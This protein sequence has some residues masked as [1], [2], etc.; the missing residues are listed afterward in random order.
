MNLKKTKCYYS[1]LMEKNKLFGQ[2]HRSQLCQ[3]TA[4]VSQ[5]PIFPGEVLKCKWMHLYLLEGECPQD[6][7]IYILGNE[8]LSN[9]HN[10]I[11]E[12]LIYKVK[13]S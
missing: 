4:D 9:I 6:I 7:C 13:C 8:L 2:P 11:N 1:Q 3:L 5:S 10:K 12:H